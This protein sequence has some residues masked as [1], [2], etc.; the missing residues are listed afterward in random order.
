MRV[1]SRGLFALIFV[2][3]TSNLYAEYLYKD[4]VIGNKKLDESIETL[5]KELFDKTGIAVRLVVL[6]KLPN[7]ETIAEY[8]KKLADKFDTPTV[9][10]TFSKEDHKV[11][12]LAKP[13]SLYKYFDKKQILSPVASFSQAFFMALF[14]THSWKEFKET[15]TDYG[16]TIIPLLAQK[17][18]KP[19]EAEKKYAGALFNGYADVV[20]QIAKAKG[21]KLEHA[22]SDDNKNTLF[23][24]KLIFYGSILY[25]LFIYFRKK[26]KGTS[27]NPKPSQSQKEG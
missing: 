18:K 26:F 13:H 4:E 24:I 10:L 23:F 5:G 22:V 14:F 11:D 27:K 19:G 21:V 3:F 1:F 17:S 7:G 8:E 6:E 12:I 20:D 9:L 25:F 2:I 15:A 16:G